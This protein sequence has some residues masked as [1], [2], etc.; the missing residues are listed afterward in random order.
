MNPVDN[1]IIDSPDCIHYMNNYDIMLLLETWL[2][3]HFH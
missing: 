1:F 2:K 3:C